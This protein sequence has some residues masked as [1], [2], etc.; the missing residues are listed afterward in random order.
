M[1]S[2][3]A[4]AVS[5]LAVLAIVAILRRTGKLPALLAAH[6]DMVSLVLG[7]LVSI[8]TANML[9][10]WFT[11]VPEDFLSWSYAAYFGFI[12]VFQIVGL[13]L[14]RIAMGLPARVKPRNQ[15]S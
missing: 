3:N 7:I 11:P 5:Y 9:W 1:L 13:R 2:H 8:A 12:L 6:I 4:F 14:T 10:R 15:T